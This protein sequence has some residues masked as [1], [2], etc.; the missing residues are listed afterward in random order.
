[1]S[2][3]SQSFYRLL[4]LEIDRA[5]LTKGAVSLHGGGVPYSPSAHQLLITFTVKPQRCVNM[6]LLG[7]LD[8]SL[9]FKG[10]SQRQWH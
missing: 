7:E 9:L 2:I 5:H 8:G 3:G 4:N 1:M 6:S 10:K